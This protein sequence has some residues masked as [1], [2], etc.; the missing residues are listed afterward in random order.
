MESLKLV[1]VPINYIH[2]YTR[3][4]TGK[5]ST[6]NKYGLSSQ[7]H[8]C[9]EYI[10]KFYPNIKNISYWKD[11]GSSYK[12]NKI[13]PDMGELIQKLKPKT[14]LLISEVSRLGRSLK[15][16][17]N[18]LKIIRKKKSYIISIS[19]N[20]VFGKTKLNDN[21]FIQKIMQSE[22]ESDN[23]SIRVKN[24]HKYIKQNGGY[25]GKPPFGYK[26][27][28]NVH[29]IPILKENSLDFKLIDNIIDL[30]K[31]C[32]SYDE[33][34]EKLNSNNI[35]H[36]NKLWTTKKIKDIL[37]KFYPEHMLLDINHKNQNIIIVNNTCT[38]DKTSSLHNR[39]KNTIY[40]NLKI[41]VNNNVRSVYY[42]SPTR[43]S[44]TTHSNSGHII[45]DFLL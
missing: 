27:E 38:T 19:D 4:S 45:N 12:T 26:I 34:K 2:V 9:D 25:I 7:S 40:N 3:V 15:M 28:K 16:V 14:I 21:Y 35:I 5:Q 13:L 6:D 24:I 23:L 11:V 29:N 1:S 32:C 43:F 37:N 33:I 18:I 22:K 42:S 39:L 20:L 17:E 10:N 30:T 36:K 31:E 8:L 41:T 44:N